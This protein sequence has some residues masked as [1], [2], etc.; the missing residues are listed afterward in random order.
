M[1]QTLLQQT[2]GD[3][4]ITVRSVTGLKLSYG[5]APTDVLGDKTTGRKL[6]RAAGR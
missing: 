6:S 4:R 2:A 5:A 1:F 3:Q